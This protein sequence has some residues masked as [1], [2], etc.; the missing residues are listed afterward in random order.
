LLREG[1]IVAKATSVAR[2]LWTK[3]ASNEGLRRS[4]NEVL[5]TES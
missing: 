3:V 4:N 5:I 2:V 1:N